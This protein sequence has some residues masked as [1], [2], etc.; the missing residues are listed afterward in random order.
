M[1]TR[2]RRKVKCQCCKH[3][4]SAHMYDPAELGRMPPAKCSIPGCACVRFQKDAT[5]KPVPYRSR[6]YDRSLRDTRQS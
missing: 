6:S 5:P 4:V 1:A 3:H 2:I